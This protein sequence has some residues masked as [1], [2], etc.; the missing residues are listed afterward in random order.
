[1]QR[2]VNMDTFLVLTSSV[3]NFLRILGHFG[4]LYNRHSL[5]KG[6]CSRHPKCW[7]RLCVLINVQHPYF[8]AVSECY[9]KRPKTGEFG[10]ITNWLLLIAKCHFWNT[11]TVVWCYFFLC[12]T[13][14]FTYSVFLPFFPL[15]CSSERKFTS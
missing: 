3:F 14:W 2:R 1:M 11:K 8:T 10:G 7:I 15:R 5:L 12:Y 6:L 13:S 4:K 9:S